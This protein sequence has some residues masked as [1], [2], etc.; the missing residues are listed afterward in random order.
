MC[1]Y[2]IVDGEIVSVSR[3]APAQPNRI[4]GEYVSVGGARCNV[5]D[6]PNSVVSEL[7]IEGPIA[8]FDALLNRVSVL[9]E[10]GKWIPEHEIKNEEALY[11]EERERLARRDRLAAEFA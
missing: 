10:Y 3:H 7:Y 4:L 11:D 8:D 9:V 5:F 1:Y 2:R 6:V